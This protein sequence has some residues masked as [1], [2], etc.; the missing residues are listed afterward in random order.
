MLLFVI[1]GHALFI[2]GKPGHRVD[3][4]DMNSDTL[5]GKTFFKGGLKGIITIKVTR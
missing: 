2:L 5:Q 3:V 1:D 4:R